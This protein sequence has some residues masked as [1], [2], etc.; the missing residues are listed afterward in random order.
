MNLFGIELRHHALWSMPGKL[1]SRGLMIKKI[2]NE[3]NHL[4]ILSPM[5]RTLH[6]LSF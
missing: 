2:P 5:L 6:E 1:M 3:K 4:F